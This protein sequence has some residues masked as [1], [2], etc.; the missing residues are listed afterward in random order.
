MSAPWTDFTPRMIAEMTAS[1]ASWLEWR[2]SAALRNSA[3]RSLLVA[4]SIP[5]RQPRPRNPRM[6]DPV[7]QG[8]G[9]QFGGQRESRGCACKGRGRWTGRLEVL[10]A[11]RSDDDWQLAVQTTAAVVN[12]GERARVAWPARCAGGPLFR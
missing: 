6:S 2:A 5:R 12:C 7:Q 11:Q 10:S 3:G 1:H 4:N 8:G 9:V